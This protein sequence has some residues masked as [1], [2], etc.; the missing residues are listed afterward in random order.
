[1]ASLLGR[2]A[3]WAP[4]EFDLLVD[5]PV[6]HDRASV[7][8]FGAREVGQEWVLGVEGTVRARPEGQANP[9]MPTGEV[10]VLAHALVVLNPSR[11]PPFEVARDVEVDEVNRLRYRYLYLRRP[12]VQVRI[13]APFNL[14][15]IERKN[16]ATQLQENTDEIM[17]RIAAMLPAEYRGVYAED[18]RLKTRLVSL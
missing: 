3:G 2:H 6:Q 14:P 7:D 18:P 5:K 13:G 12:R 1:M 11:T 16:R 9:D 15:A 4:P 10:E 17:L 8:L